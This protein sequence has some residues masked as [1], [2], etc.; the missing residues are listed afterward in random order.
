MYPDLLIRTTRDVDERIRSRR[1][2]KGRRRYRLERAGRVAS[3]LDRARRQRAADSAARDGRCGGEHE[4]TRTAVRQG[5]F[6]REDLDG[7]EA[8]EVSAHTKGVRKKEGKSLGVLER[9][10]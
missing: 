1:R 8:A 9:E 4:N 10:H 3:R 6:A 7:Q 5:G 2:R